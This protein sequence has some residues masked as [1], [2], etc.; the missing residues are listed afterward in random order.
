MLLVS[1]HQRLM[2]GVLEHVFKCKT[3]GSESKDV[4]LQLSFCRECVCGGG[5]VCGCSLFLLGPSCVC[6]EWCGSN[7]ANYSRNWVKD[8]N[9][10]QLQLLGESRP[11]PALACTHTQDGTFLSAKIKL[12]SLLPAQSRC[13]F[14]VSVFSTV[15]MRS[16]SFSFN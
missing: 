10:W 11:H 4:P 13:L 8:L 6:C 5:Q 2:G 15:V 3:F 1:A 9:C 7:L 12:A 14:V 16:A